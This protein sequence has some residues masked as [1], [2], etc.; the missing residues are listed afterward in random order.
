VFD[1]DAVVIGAGPAGAA[2]A[3]L[4]ADAG[5]RVILIEQHSFPRPKVC[6]ECIAA[7]NLSLLDHLGIGRAFQ[8][9]A[10]PELRQIGWMGAGA[11]VIADMPACANG[12]YR[13]GR[14]LGRESLDTLLM[15]RAAT[16]GVSVLQ[17]AK[18][19]RIGGVAG[20]F[21]CT[22]ELPST[23]T[24][25]DRE[26]IIEE[27]LYA[28]VVIDAHGSWERG[29]AS[30]AVQ[31]TRAP[32]RDSDLLA[33][34][35]CFRNA[36]LQSGLLP[37]LSLPGGYG[38]LVAADDH[39]TTIAC[40]LRR[41]VLKRCREAAP[42]LS[43]GM[44]VEAH[45]R[46][47]CGEIN[48]VLQGAEL[49]GPWLSV[50]PV[51]PG[52]RVDT[53]DGVLRVGNAAGETHPLIGEGITMALQSAGLLVH[54]LAREIGTFDVRR[55][56]EVESAYATA[57]RRA[58]MPMLRWAAAYAHIAM[59]PVLAAPA[60]DFLRRVPRA[61]TVAARL[62]GKARSAAVQFNSPEVMA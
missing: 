23:G 3:I 2:A 20:R 36:R 54:H 55:R 5:W 47:S 26:V 49:I 14:A 10:G 29:P 61:L 37:V 9:L 34:K 56:F 52:I 8:R 15:E 43:A 53:T 33:F 24:G 13:F 25:G 62:A 44:A 38:G 40:C 16:V 22:V 46:R 11:M 4:L 30:S 31:T 42:G 51:R 7:G 21:E 57:W 50:G 1:A 12:P 59:S 48:E 17:P 35:A 27:T 18:A 6:G 28:P 60:T 45:L 32:R 39:R 19:I 41:D 58:F